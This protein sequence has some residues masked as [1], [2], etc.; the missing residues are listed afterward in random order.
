[1]PR[2]FKGDLG[3]DLHDLAREFQ[4][5][6]R[7]ETNVHIVND[8]PEVDHDIGVSLYVIAHEALSNTRKYAQASKVWI[9]LTVEG[10]V[11]RME[12]RD[13]GCGFDPTIEIPESHHGL[14]NMASRASLV[15]AQLKVESAPGQGTAVKVEL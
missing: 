4:E 5:H 1:R 7:I 11:L 12:L 13:D 6:S 2:Q 14:R 3:H 10:G 8:L 9:S 15:G